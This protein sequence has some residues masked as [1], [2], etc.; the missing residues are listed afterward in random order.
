MD[1]ENNTN[2][3]EKKHRWLRLQSILA[4]LKSKEKVNFRIFKD[5]LASVHPEISFSSRT[6]TRDIDF[7]K[8]EL[9]API[10]YDASNKQFYLKDP[11]WTPDAMLPISGEIKTLLLGQ[12]ISDKFMP[13]GLRG[14]FDKLVNA[15]LMENA[16]CIPEN[17]YLEN[18]QIITPDFSPQVPLDVFKVVYQAWENRNYLSFTYTSAN[19][20]KSEKMVEPCVLAW[21]S[22]TWY[23]KGFL[24][25]ENGIPLLPPFNIRVFALHRIKNPKK[26]GKFSID[27]DE[28]KRIRDKKIFNFTVLD[29]VELEFF[30]TQITERFSSNPE[31]IIS[32]DENSVKI[33]LTNIQEYAVLRLISHARGNVKVIKPESLKKSLRNMAQNIFDNNPETL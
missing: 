1:K 16:D 30:N 27:S 22:G 33:R 29:E 26:S 11:N 15:L 7:L 23:I 12:R 32:Q 8:K 17:M 10:E 21:D 20:N 13:G 18:F 5:Y 2:K 19:G 3:H 24:V 4:E 28:L 31:S 6:F 25:N 14:E 9:K